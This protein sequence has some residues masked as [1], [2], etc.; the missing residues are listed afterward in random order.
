M[1]LSYNKTGLVDAV[2]RALS[3]LSVEGGGYLR[4]VEAYRGDPGGAG[5]LREAIQLPA[6]FVSYAS[7]SYRPGPYL[8]TRETVSMNIFALCRAGA[9]PDSGAV[10]ADIRALLAGSTLGLD[11]SPLRLL[12][13]SA[14]ME[15][16]ETSVHAAVY[17]VEQTVK[18]DAQMAQG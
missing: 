6:V 3:P 5:L 7:S 12:R 17:S 2:V 8:C 9:A 4:L 1:S 14:L 16:K 11:V 13:E 10:L 15:T 18:L